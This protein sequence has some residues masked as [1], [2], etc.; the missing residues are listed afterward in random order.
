MVHG[1]VEPTEDVAKVQR[2]YAGRMLS[3][4]HCCTSWRSGKERTSRHQIGPMTPRDQALKS[5]WPQD[6]LDNRDPVDNQDGLV[7]Q[8]VLLLTSICTAAANPTQV[9]RSTVAAIL[10]PGV[11]PTVKG[12]P[13]LHPHWFRTLPIGPAPM[14]HARCR[15]FGGELQGLDGHNP[16]AKWVA[17]FCTIYPHHAIY[18]TNSVRYWNDD[19]DTIQILQF[20]C[21]NA[22]IQ[23][24]TLDNMSHLNPPGSRYN[25]LCYMCSKL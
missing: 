12:C 5:Q 19:N 15:S 6:L 1:C 10:S 14:A 8:N 21:L 3:G 16:L 13:A 7:N 22:T 20:Y 25:S 18:V 4:G 24:P 2:V 9:V 17:Q 11:R 23:R